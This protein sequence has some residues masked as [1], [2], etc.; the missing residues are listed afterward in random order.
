MNIWR[1]LALLAFLI[2]G[3]A[4][5]EVPVVT[6]PRE[7]SNTE[8]KMIVAE[9]LGTKKESVMVRLKDGKIVP[10]LL[11][12][13]C[14]ADKSFIR[15]NPLTYREVWKAWPSEVEMPMTV[16]GN[17]GTPLMKDLAQVFE[18]TYAL[19]QKSPFGLLA[20]APGDRFEAKLFGTLQTYQQQGGPPNSAGV[21]LPKTKTF[22]APLD[23]MGVR[24]DSSVWRRIP[25]SRCDTS[26]VIHELTHM[27]THDML[28]TLP[29]WVNEGYAEYIANIPI[30]G[31]VFRIS[32][33][34]IRDGIVDS[35]VLDYEKWLSGRDGVIRKIGAADR[36]G[37]LKENLPKLP[38]AS[39]VLGITDRNWQ[40]YNGPVYSLRGTTFDYAG[41][42]GLYRTAQL[43]IYYFLHLDGDDGVSK[44]TRFVS[45]KRQLSAEIAT[46]RSAFEEYERKM[47]EFLKLPGVEKL[48]DGR[49]RYPGNL[50]IPEAPKAPVDVAEIESSGL[51]ILLAGETPETLGK[52]IEAALIKDLA[53]PLKF[54]AE[55]N[56]R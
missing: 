2:N 9:Y 17:L 49:I 48:E 40:S 11:S 30:E 31:D 55:V 26:T 27:L 56:S 42:M 19:H 29:I 15:K 13:L 34:K 52:K 14:E 6:G 12:K 36:A 45:G 47:E 1:F 21:Y 39:F 24:V 33:T 46:Y 32:G 25:R 53:L 43:I 35:F 54:G 28:V 7:W 5:G 51:E 20:K 3:H 37:F 18:L 8:G 23:L 16:D 44:L 4:W 50:K 22:L 38:S 41:K 10:I